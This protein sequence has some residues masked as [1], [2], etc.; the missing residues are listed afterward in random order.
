ML[1]HTYYCYSHL[2]TK[3]YLK[4]RFTF[5]LPINSIN[6]SNSCNT[7]NTKFY[8]HLNI[9]RTSVVLPWLGLKA[10]SQSSRAK[11]KPAIA[12]VTACDFKWLSH[13][14]AT[15]WILNRKEVR[16]SAFWRFMKV[17]V[18]YM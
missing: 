11:M 18:H 5:K 3:Q 10:A 2:G 12:D 4:F 17:R 9:D 15:A 13:G 16:K 1:V 14:G 8:S 7:F 6:T